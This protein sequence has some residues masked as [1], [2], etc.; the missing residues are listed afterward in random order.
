MILRPDVRDLRVIASSLGRVV[1]GVGALMVLPAAVAAGHHEWDAMSA[2]L[3]SGALAVLTGRLATLL[4]PS[5]RPATW[6]HGMVTIGLSWLVAP[7][8]AGLPLFLAGHA[9]GFLD[10]YFEALSGLTTTG[11]TLVQDLD[12]LAVSL[13]LWR[14]LLQFVG[15]QSIVI[16]ILTMFTT[17]SGHGGSLSLGDI[18]DN[19]ITPNVSR[20]G[21]FI[22][23]VAAAF[24]AT[25]VT[26][27]TIA[28]I[29]AGLGPGR[30]LTHAG[31][32]FLTAYDTGGFSLQSTSAS[33]YHSGAVEAIVIVLMI[34]GALSYGIHFELWRGNR[35]ELLRNIETRTMGLTF[36]ALLTVTFVGLGRSGAFTDVG[37]MFRQGLFTLVSAHT[38]SG[39]TLSD[40]RLIVTDW[41]LLAPAAMVAAM[42][43]GGMASSSAG[44]IKAIRVGLMLKGIFQEV[45]RV[46]LPESAVVL[47]T[48]HQHRRQV[49]RDVH[50]RGAATVLLLF[51]FTFL[52]GGLITLFTIPD[53]DFTEALFES[54]AAASNTGMSVGI[55]EPS[56]PAV[57]KV[58][59]ALQMWF[60]RLEF[61]AVFALLGYAFAFVRGRT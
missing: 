35:R 5:R 38:T 61:M 13:N 26:A 28:G 8:F 25:G 47:A 17:T 59:Y 54:T 56:A 32:L 40:P 3:L 11:L 42:S 53:V 49:L 36:L 50:I 39:L 27:L 15:G 23:T 58:V 41:G 55:L 4:L 44:G 46:L 52:V 18:R 31:A 57:L 16:V 12:H 37:P 2:L 33:Y 22:L 19:R 51:L 60:G 20:T 7:V 45:R 34:A 6:T 30:A 1:A 29:A 24:A 10:G 9:D 43:V 48:Y 21:R 14:H